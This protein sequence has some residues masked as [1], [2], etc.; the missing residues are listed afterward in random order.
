MTTSTSPTQPD[1]PSSAGVLGVLHA[2]GFVQNVTDEAGLAAAFA[3]GPVT[4]YV[5]FDPTAPSLHAG[6]LVG[7]M[8]M[9]WLQRHGHRPIALAGGATGRIGDPSGRD[10]EREVLDDA[11][12]DRHLAGIRRQLGLVLDLTGE[13][14]SGHGGPGG[15]LVD[16][17]DWTAPVR[18]LDFLQEVGAYA[19]VNQ[20]I[21]R[22]SVKRRLEEREQGLTYAE[23]SYQLLQA[24][25]FAHLYEQHGCVLQ[26]GGSDQWG[27]IVAGID[28]IRRRGGGQAYGLVW[29]L[30]TTADGSKF[31]KSAGN[32]VWLDA[33]LTSAY[34]YYQYWVNAADA[35]VVRFLKLFTFL[36]L[37]TIAELE[38]EHTRDPAARVAHRVLAREATRI[39]HGDA[40]VAAAEDATAVL[41][42]D[43]PFAGLSDDVLTSAFEEAP[44]VT[45]D[46][47]LLEG[48]GVG[49][50]EAMTAVG[51]TKANGEARRLVQ[52]GAVRL[53]NALV[54]DAQYR[55]GPGDLAGESTAVIRAGKKRY[56]LVRFS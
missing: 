12:I 10:T 30:L 35:D 47:A 40:G 46:R 25:D 17:H 39:I 41:F 27:N 14:S 23:F 43:E 2:R 4:Y 15:L 9:A 26:G 24:F 7:M 20:M 22:E 52:Q 19:S 34:A 18:V 21:A 55:L 49:L 31:G 32:A 3:A 33:G 38:V 44:S 51:L 54:D 36:E 11:T 48:G 13:A 45:L 1:T 29:P 53:N 6:N 42:G 16:N 37:E 50:L 5:G 8:A 28:L 56:G